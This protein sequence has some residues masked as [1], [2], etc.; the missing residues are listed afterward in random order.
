[1][2]AGTAVLR[3][4]MAAGLGGLAF[5]LFV[6]VMAFAL[7]TN[8]SSGPSDSMTRYFTTAGK[9]VELSAVARPMSGQVVDAITE[10]V[11]RDTDGSATRSTEL[12]AIDPDHV[13]PPLIR[14]LARE[15]RPRA[16]SAVDAVFELEQA[17]PLPAAEAA[18]PPVVAAP[19]EPALQPGEVVQATVSFYYCERGDEGLH[20]GDGGGFCGV[21]RDGTV[22]YPGAAACAYAYLG[23]RFRVLGDPLDRVYVCA[24]TGSAVHGLHRDIWF[25]SSD[26]GWDWQRAIGQ[27]ATIEILP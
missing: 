1:Q 7:T 10:A 6:G 23:Q 21:M 27:V 26:D 24:D 16:S 5:A 12:V 3:R 13:D 8:P 25:M 9:V 14:A 4:A 20:A 17:I 15:S 22:V 11:I 2:R 19:R 18:S